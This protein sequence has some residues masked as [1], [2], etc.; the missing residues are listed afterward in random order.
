MHWLFFWSLFRYFCSHHQIK[1]KILNKFILLLVGLFLV[2]NVSSQVNSGVRLNGKIISDYPDMEG[3]YI[4][5]LATDISIVSDKNGYFT[6]RASVGD[7]LLF[8]AVQFKG[9]KI[10]LKSEDFSKDIFFVKLE[11]MN[12]ILDEVKIQQ[13]RNINSVSL[14]LVS[15][16]QKQYTPAER[17][18]KS[19]GQFKWYSPLLIPLGG[20]SIDGL[21]NT[22]SGRTSMLQQNLLTEK[23]EFLLKKIYTLYDDKYFTET[24]KIPS[25]YIKG[26]Q[27]YITEDQKFVAAMNNNNKTMATFLMTELSVE[28]LQIIKE[29]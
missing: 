18:L 17:R 19:A 21:L 22:I 26:F 14:G 24:L 4:A 10:K 7:T 3:I 1:I 12:T 5:N 23:K 2:N 13:Y 29:K 15:K 16:N 8:S 20:M 25:D 6:L 27:Y 9:L 11:T 28:Y